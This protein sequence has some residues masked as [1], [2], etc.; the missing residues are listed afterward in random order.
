VPLA[1]AG[2]SFGA[3]AAL[4]AAAEVAGLAHVVAIAPPIAF[5]EWEF[6]GTLRVPV[7]VIVGDRDQYCDV[8]RV[9][10]LRDPL[11]IRIIRGADHFLSGHEGAVAAAVV[12]ALG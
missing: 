7:T 3:W 12:T 2:Y 10:S 9:A 11:A 1:L 5:G 8:T 4:T 6:L